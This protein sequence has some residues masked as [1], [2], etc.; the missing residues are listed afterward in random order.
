M[1]LKLIET[2]DLSE[3]FLS[4][5]PFPE[6]WK[7]R[8][9]CKMFE[10]QV[11]NQIAHV[12]M[13]KQYLPF[14]FPKARELTLSSLKQSNLVISK[15]QFPAL[16]VLSMTSCHMTEL[17]VEPNI[18]QFHNHFNVIE[19]YR[20]PLQTLQ[21]IIETTD[22]LLRA[23]TYLPCLTDLVSYHPMKEI[24]SLESRTPNLV[25][26]KTLVKQSVACIPNLPLEILT[27][28]GYP[29]TSIFIPQVTSLQIL[30]LFDVNEIQLGS[31]LF[32]HLERLVVSLQNA[33]VIQDWRLPK[34][35][36]FELFSHRVC[37]LDVF[38]CCPKIVYLETNRV[39]LIVRNCLHLHTLKAKESQVLHLENAPSLQRFQFHGIQDSVLQ[40]KTLLPSLKE[41]D[42]CVVNAK[43]FQEWLMPNLQ[44]LQL[45]VEEPYM[46][47][48][49]VQCPN[50]TDVSVR[51]V[52]VIASHCVHLKTFEA[53][54]FTRLQLNDLPSLL[55][56]HLPSDVLD[57][58][59]LDR[60][61]FH[62]LTV[63]EL[64]LSFD[65]KHKA[66]QI[67]EQTCALTILYMQLH[68]S[69]GT[70]NQELVD[71]LHKALEKVP[72]CTLKII[73]P[74]GKART[75]Y[76]TKKFVLKLKRKNLDDLVSF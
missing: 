15:T 24:S 63:L 12:Q 52:N 16:Q 75:T 10:M 21:S 41:F 40:T 31:T 42:A 59:C 14:R 57:N 66:L 62:Q 55:K 37:T 11:P 39:R 26:L 7:L 72:N 2:P 4:C 28:H 44:R 58:S 1:L 38:A 56:L 48:L 20:L 67:L 36:H 47:D 68:I 45:I 25:R 22:T 73:L 34:L 3:W 8:Q 19:T 53:Y 29:N 61:P 30:E 17:V 33:D 74:S 23:L 6:G 35:Q 54:K 13:H 18:S 46:L 51:N 69:E 60:L 43:L 49:F 64:C 65:T 76:N 71:V 32:P 5:F 27:I 50:V 9:L 70:T